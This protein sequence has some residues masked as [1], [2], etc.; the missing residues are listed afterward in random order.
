MFK[1]SDLLAFIEG[2]RDAN[3]SVGQKILQELPTN[4]KLRQ[5][6]AELQR[7][8]YL[9]DS[10]IPSV[11]PSAQFLLEVNKLGT[12]WLEQQQRWRNRGQQR[13]LQSPYRY[14]LALFFALF[15]LIAAILIFRS[16]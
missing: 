6:M 2:N 5:R 1:Q 14:G 16:A 15:F 3:P 12:V 8:L 7:D 4:P 10:E 11:Q 9:V 13:L